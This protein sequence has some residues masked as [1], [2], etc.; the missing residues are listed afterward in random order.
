MSEQKYFLKIAQDLGIGSRQVEATVGLLNEGAT[1][2]FISRYRK[3]LT[4]SLDEVAIAAIR[5]EIERLRELDKRRDT[6]LNSIKEQGKLT[7]ELEKDILAAATM[8]RLEDLY[9]PYK[10][11]RRTKATIARERGLEPL[12]LTIFSQEVKDIDAE[13]AKFIDAEKEVNNESEALQGARDIIAEMINEDAVCR[14]KMRTLFTDKA[15]IT[16]TV[17]KGKE[18]E[19][20]KYRDYFEWS[21]LL[22]NTP[23]HRLLA[24]RRGEKEMILSL[25][26]A[27]VKDDAIDIIEG[28]FVKS[29]GEAAEQI[30]I[31]IDDCYKR[32][33]APSIETEM[34]LLTKKGADEKAIVVF[35]D[36]LRELLLAA[37]MGQK[38]ILAIDP[39]FRTGCK[40]VVLNPQGKLLENTVIYPTASSQGKMIEA[41]AVVLALCQRFQIEAIAIGNGTAS[42]ETETFVRGI[43]D[44]PKDVSVVM[45][46]EA[47]ASV[48]SASEVAREEFPDYDVTVRGAV[49]IGRR[50]ADPLAELV[51]IDPKSI[52][53]GQY[54]HD[55]DQTALKNKLDEVVGSCVN[56]VGVEVNTASKQLLTYVSGLGP[57]LAQ[58]IINYRN[59]NG[60]FKSRKDLKAVPRM[61]EKVFEQAAGFL[62]ILNGTHPLD[63]SAVHPESYHIVEQMAKDLGC[64]VDDLIADKEVRKK[65]DLK[66]YV[67]ETVGLPTLND[68]MQ[69]L[70]KPGRDPRKVFEAFK[71]ADDVNEIADLKVGMR[72]PGIVTNVTNFGAFVDVGVHQDG[73]VHLSQLS[74]RFITDANEVVKVAQQ[75]L[76]TVTEV[77]VDRKRIALTMKDES[78][79]VQRTKAEKEKMRNDRTNRPSQQQ[80]SKPKAEEPQDMNSMLAA[81]KN[82]WK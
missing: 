37:P 36:N 2:P 48:Y 12:A 59:E 44:L 14:D 41:E 17:M 78:A 51:K 76:V 73:L 6:I 68:I 79:P 66:K 63:S 74:N 56:A 70:D 13:A 19:G 26:I 64:K 53:V 29:R 40:V 47:G 65:I 3:E 43:K 9:L 52:G 23:S 34:R 75:V 60:A 81:L 33:L 25:D 30:K 39:G 35:A 69:E 7:D 61:G 71:F 55:V 8:S 4:G 49:S 50:L 46:N 5:D 21:E 42:R 24:M 11:K 54:Q 62:R 27:P 31:A 20:V 10:P 72:L 80:Q 22:K 28:V 45:V 18:E 15:M 77:D 82:K 1:I 38:C 16:S 57:A 67:S 58:N 32:L